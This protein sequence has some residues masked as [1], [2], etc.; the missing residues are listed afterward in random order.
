MPMR[1]PRRPRGG[2]VAGLLPAAGAEIGGG[3]DE[4]AVERQDQAHGQLG[5]GDGVLA[6]AVGDV[7]AARAGGRDVDGVDPGAGADDEVELRPAAMA[8]PVTS[9]ERTTRMPTPSSAPGSVS[10]V[11]SGRETISTPRTLSSSRRWVSILSATSRRM[12]AGN[13]PGFGVIPLALLAM[14]GLGGC[15]DHHVSPWG[16][17]ERPTLRPYLPRP[18]LD[19]QLAAI[20]AETSELGLGRS[21]ELE[22]KLPRG[23]GPLVIRAYSGRDVGRRALHA[24]RVA[25]ARGVVMAV[26]PLD[27]R[28]VTRDRATELVPALVTSASG[29]AYTA[30][31][32]LNGDG[33]PDVALK[34]E[35]GAIE[36]WGIAATGASPYAVEMQVLPTRVE[37]VDGD[38]RLD[39]VGRVAVA[40]GDPLAPVLDDAAIFE[41]GRYT[42]AAPG[43]KAMHEARLRELSTTEARERAAA[44]EASDA[45]AG[46]GDAGAAAPPP[47]SDEVRLRRALERAW[48][49][50]LAGK[51]KEAELKALDREIVPPPLRASFGAFRRAIEMA[52]AGRR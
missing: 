19:G 38:G 34:S 25:S 14:A 4:A 44:E 43:V 20:D 28:D 40:E 26:G 52:A 21:F 47:I 9:V 23:G 13:I 33:T 27:A 3:V 2:G 31:T 24:V 51:P 37:D 41:R 7:D 18:D 50:I 17:V 15:S 11:R 45:G 5:D 32:D 8:S 42:D 29:D 10:L 22:T 36:L 1:W 49:G 6:R 39:L 46:P 30:G 35:S 48:H 12:R 16:S